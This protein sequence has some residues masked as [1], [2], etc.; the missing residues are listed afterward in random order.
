MV[1]ILLDTNI[2][3][4]AFEGHPTYMHFLRTIADEQIGISVISYMEMLVGARDDQDARAIQS[5]MRDFDVIPLSVGIADD[6]AATFR[7]RK[8]KSLRRPWF[9][10]TIIA[11]TA[12]SMG[13]RLA[14]NNPKDFAMFS[15][16]KIVV[17]E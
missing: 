15:G 2:V 14:T 3:I 6:S 17:P 1:D 16:L 9:A 5:F 7:K 8:H 13:V 4:Y 10:D 12:L 11:Q